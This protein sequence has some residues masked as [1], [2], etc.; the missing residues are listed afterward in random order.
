MTPDRREV[1]ATAVEYSLM[2][3]LIALG[4]FGSVLLLGHAV[5]ALSDISCGPFI[6]C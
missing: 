1:D 4:I 6:D 5:V 3:S 2:V